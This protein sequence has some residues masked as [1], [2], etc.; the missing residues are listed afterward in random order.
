MQVM[1]T[2]ERIGWAYRGEVVD[3]TT[4][5]TLFRTPLEYMEPISAKDAAKRM[6]EAVEHAEDAA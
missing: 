3:A 2:A 1:Y 6:W 5:R 4:Y